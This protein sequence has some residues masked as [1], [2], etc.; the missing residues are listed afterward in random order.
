MSAGAGD[1]A[2]VTVRVRATP[3]RAFALFTEEI[4]AWWRRGAKY[5]AAGAA[6][7][8]LVLEPG[9]GG[10][11]VEHIGAR[12]VELGRVL[13]WDPPHG[14]TL[15]WHGPAFGPG[16]ETRVEVRFRAQGAG[17]LVT[18]RHSGWSALPDDHPARHGR[19]GAAFAAELG[20][21]WAGLLGSLRER[22]EAPP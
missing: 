18:V 20:S 5:R 21:W 14:L 1:A 3:E 6:P 13:A 19:S 8:T 9:V 11:L 12:R 2:S 17:T 15:A 4:D 22:D 16:E 10:R 7:S